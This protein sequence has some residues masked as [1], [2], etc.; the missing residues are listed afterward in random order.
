M[1]W[2]EIEEIGRKTNRLQF[3]KKHNT[4]KIFNKWQHY[5]KPVGYKLVSFCYKYNFKFKVIQIN[6][7]KTTNTQN[8]IHTIFYNFLIFIY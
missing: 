4:A 8:K 7:I 2:P 1:T 5:T 6:I 3:I